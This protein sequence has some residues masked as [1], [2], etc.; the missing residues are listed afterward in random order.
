MFSKNSIRLVFLINKLVFS[1]SFVEFDSNESDSENENHV[2]HEYTSNSDVSEEEIVSLLEE[3]YRF[4]NDNTTKRYRIASG[5][6]AYPGTKLK[7]FKY[8][9]QT[10]NF[11]K[12]KYFFF[13]HFE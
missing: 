7:Y 10:T 6:R 3:K 1:L 12:S 8:F 2:S 13:C 4:K 5:G 11:R 9:I